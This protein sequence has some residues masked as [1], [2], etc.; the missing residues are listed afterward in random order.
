MLTDEYRFK[1]LKELQQDPD[2]SQRELASRLGISLGKVNFCLKALIEKGLVKVENFRNNANKVSYLYL[3]TPKG[4]ED[5]AILT[6]HFLQKKLQE[7]ESLTQEIEELRK[8]V[9]TK[10]SEND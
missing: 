7:Y 4:I 1:I 10:K 9:L 2:I 3:L 6:R 8:E 5:R